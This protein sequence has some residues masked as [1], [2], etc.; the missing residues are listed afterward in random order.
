LTTRNAIA[1]AL[2]ANDYGLTGM[3]L[4]LVKY[5]RR[6]G[7]SI[8]S[9]WRA[10]HGGTAV[11]Y[12]LLIPLFLS[13][14]IAA[15]ETT[16]YLFAQQTLQTA[17]DE[18]GRMFMT[19]QGQTSAVTQSQ[20]TNTICPMI[21]PLFNCSQLMVDVE[22]YASFSGANVSAP[23]LTYNAQGQ[24]TNTWSYNPGGPGDI[25]VVRLIYQWSVI[26]G[27]LGFTLAN[28]QNGTA[29]MLGVTAFR[30]EPY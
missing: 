9:F 27:P 10:R 2:G 1:P 17:A 28:L 11:E 4:N 22:S 3:S 19:G 6:L 14:L 25:I 30:V 15:F 26:G 23:T 29:E 13:T 18:A 20:F 24:V 7:T 5:L 21:Q 12:A 16:I 8:V